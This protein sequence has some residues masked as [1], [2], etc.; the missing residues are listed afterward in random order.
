[1]GSTLYPLDSKY[2]ITEL[3]TL[4]LTC[5]FILMGFVILSCHRPTSIKANVAF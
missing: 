4:Q 1:M 5:F 3:V 2:F